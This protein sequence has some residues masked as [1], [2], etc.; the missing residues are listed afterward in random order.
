M[1][2]NAIIRK[3]LNCG[4]SDNTHGILGDR[5]GTKDQEKSSLLFLFFSWY[6]SAQCVKRR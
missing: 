6:N 3:V 2:L 5:R 1:N 4:N